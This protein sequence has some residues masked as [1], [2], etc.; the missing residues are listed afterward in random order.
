MH[1]WCV[2]RYVV[3]MSQGVHWVLLRGVGVRLEV[4]VHYTLEPRS[5]RVPAVTH[6]FLRN[7][8][9]RVHEPHSD[10]ITCY[11]AMNSLVILP[12]LPAISMCSGRVRMRTERRYNS[13]VRESMS[14]QG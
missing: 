10:E 8:R 9:S 3:R 14:E 6:M 5:K 2:M 7:F 13:R 1:A 4:Q 12:Y 11:L